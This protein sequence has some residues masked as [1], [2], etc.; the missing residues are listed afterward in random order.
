VL[1]IEDAATNPAAFRWNGPISPAALDAW[2]LPRALS[3]PADLRHF[4]IATGGGTAFES[5]VLHGPFG[6]S[7]VGH[8]FDGPN[9]SYHSR[10]LT[11]DLLLFHAGT[12]ISAVRHG[13]GRYLLMEPDHTLVA[14][15]PSFEAWYVASI[16]REF[17]EKYGL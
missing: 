6:D 17:G 11:P 14:E 2:L 3:V 9:A 8:D 16:R 5:E 15:L 10:G 13:D 4:W 12:W 7:A 1:I